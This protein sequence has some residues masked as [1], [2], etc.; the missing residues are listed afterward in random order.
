MAGWAFRSAGAWGCGARPAPAAPARMCRH[1]SGACAGTCKMHAAEMALRTCHTFHTMLTRSGPLENVQQSEKL[2]LHALSA[3]LLGKTGC[4]AQKEQLIMFFN[5]DRWR[6][7]RA[8]QISRHKLACLNTNCKPISHLLGSLSICVLHECLEALALLK[9]GDLLDQ[10]ECRE[11]Q[12]QSVECHIHVRLRAHAG[13]SSDSTPAIP[14]NTA[15]HLHY[16]TPC[17]RRFQSQ[18]SEVEHE[19]RSATEPPWQVHK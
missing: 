1:M 11:D 19:S 8:Q 15:A 13:T 7:L 10:A 4:L 6:T 3:S 5:R 2:F 16:N 18:E 17:L 14:R 9:G 12:V